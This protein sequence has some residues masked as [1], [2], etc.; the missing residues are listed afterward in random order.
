ME[1]RWSGEL[2]GWRYLAR[3]VTGTG[4]PGDWLDTELPLLDVQITDVLSGPPQL[5][6][7]IS[8]VHARLQMPDGMPLLTEND[9]EI[10]AEKDGVIRAC[11]HLVRNGSKGQVAEIEVNGFTGY[12]KDMGFLG[13]PI[14]GPNRAKDFIDVDPL[15][16]VRYLWHHIQSVGPRSDIGLQVDPDTTTPIRIGIA[17]TTPPLTTAAE[18]IQ[19]RLRSGLSMADWTWDGAP[20]V[21]VAYREELIGEAGRDEI[22]LTV[23][24]M[25]D[26]WLS[27]YIEG[28][29]PNGTGDEGPYRLATWLTDDIGG[30]IDSLASATPFGYHERHEW[31]ADKTEILHF[32]DFGYPRLGTRRDI[33]FVVGDNVQEIPDVERDGTQS[34]NHVR[35]LGAGE[36]SRMIRAE[37][38]VDDGRLRRMITIADDSITDP[39]MAK[40]RARLEVGMR[41][42]A[43]R[44]SSF[45]VRNTG[46]T[47]LGGWGVGD[48][49]RLQSAE[50]WFHV[51]QWVRILSQ[52]ISPEDPALATC[53][54]LRA[55]RFAV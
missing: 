2:D 25:V 49:V 11:G 35:I 50:G 40:T 41:A 51:D 38:R 7:T 33:T 20:D 10:A 36:G 4:A 28:H 5:T 52:T 6:G 34:A 23:P 26:E 19:D 14:L 44:I 18:L 9:T 29:Q 42:N 46:E 13:D 24:A 30:E 43:A 22:D 16:V 21:V 3:R 47:Q 55:D 48:E 31:N 1:P 37:A 53:T 17:V 15:D 32:L 39:E 54:V 27:R 8:P 45:V 12:A